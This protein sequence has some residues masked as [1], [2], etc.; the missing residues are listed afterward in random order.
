MGH[1]YDRHIY[2][3]KV[4]VLSRRKN[5]ARIEGAASSKNFYGD[6]SRSGCML[7]SVSA[8]RSQVIL[9]S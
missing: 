7:M 6:L 3:Q 9:L 5:R 4:N 1:I 2:A 8:S